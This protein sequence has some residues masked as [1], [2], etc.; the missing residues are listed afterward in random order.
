MNVDGLVKIQNHVTPAKPV[1]E[2]AG[3]GRP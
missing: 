1:P 2:Q 3:S